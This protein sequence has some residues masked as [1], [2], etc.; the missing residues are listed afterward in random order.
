MVDCLLQL[1][2]FIVTK[3]KKHRQEND[4]LESSMRIVLVHIFTIP[5]ESSMGIIF[6]HVSAILIEQQY[7]DSLSTDIH[8]SCGKQ[9]G[10][11]FCTGICNS[12]SSVGIVLVRYV[13][14]L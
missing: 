2:I 7:G 10:D 4:V 13:Q 1:N 6:V 12:Y 5:L 14:F 8:N 9:C 11:Y 3:E